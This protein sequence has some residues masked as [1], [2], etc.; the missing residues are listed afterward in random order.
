MSEL[1][2]YIL[3]RSW[4]DFSF[5]NPDLIKPVHSALFFFAI[6]HCNRL[7][8]KR[9]FGLPAS[10]VTEAI[11]VKSY[12]TYIDAFNDLVEWG[13][14]ILYQKSKNQYSSNIIALSIY[15]K[16][17]DKALDKALIKHS[18][19]QSES[20]I[21]STIE[22][23]CESNSSIIKQRTKNNITSK[24]ALK[25]FSLIDIDIFISSKE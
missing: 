9:K 8:W 3:S 18:I 24:P 17:L 6:E 16:A 25:D 5:E 21:E 13:F 2:S 23:D 12:N 11:G 10:M 4:F 20:T 19:K 14:I 7:G 1:N 15:N 22:S